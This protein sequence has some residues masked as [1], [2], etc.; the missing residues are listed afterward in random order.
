MRREVNDRLHRRTAAFHKERRKKRL[1][2]V[3]LYIKRRRDE[4]KKKEAKVCILSMWG[5]CFCRAVSCWLYAVGFK[6]VEPARCLGLVSW[7]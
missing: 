6:V 3:D 4:L 2:Y 7:E 5:F 1:E